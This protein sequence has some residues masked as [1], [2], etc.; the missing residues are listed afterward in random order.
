M[1]ASWYARFAVLRCSAHSHPRRPHGRVPGLPCGA[2]LRERDAVLLPHGSVPRGPFPR[3][4]AAV[5]LRRVCS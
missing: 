1:R 2:G 5:L 3:D 4:A